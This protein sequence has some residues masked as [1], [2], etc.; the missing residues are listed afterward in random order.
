MKRYSIIHDLE[1]RTCIICGSTRDIHIHE[2]FFGRTGNRDKSI[3]HGLCVCLCARHH[4]CSNEGVH[5]NK[6]LDNKLKAYAQKIAMQKYGW[7]VDD[8]RKIF[9]KNYLD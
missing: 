8:F 9:G 7:S 4:N 1:E 2:V 5:L 3:E 6:K